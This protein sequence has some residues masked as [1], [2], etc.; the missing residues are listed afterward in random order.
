MNGQRV[1]LSVFVRD[2]GDFRTVIEQLTGASCE[3]PLD[4][5][6]APLCL[7]FD[8]IDPI[9]TGIWGLHD[10]AIAAAF[11]AGLACGL[12]PARLLL[13]SIGA[14]DSSGQGAAAGGAL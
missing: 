12:D 5:L 2:G 10:D 6:L 7:P 1:K 8:V 3:L 9:M 4:E 14:D 13:V 11:A